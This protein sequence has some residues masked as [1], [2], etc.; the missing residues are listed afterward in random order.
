MPT[1]ALA[2]P[3]AMSDVHQ[4][5]LY[6]YAIPTDR[7]NV[8]PCVDS[9][10]NSLWL[11]GG[12]APR[13]ARMAYEPPIDQAKPPQMKIPAVTAMMTR[14]AKARPFLRIAGTTGSPAKTRVFI[15][16]PHPQHAAQICR[17]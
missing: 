8:R 17:A 10:C 16:S 1:F 7:R 6:L 12:W 3:A 13:M 15:A 11:R 14:R 9:R 2:R 4:V 5:T